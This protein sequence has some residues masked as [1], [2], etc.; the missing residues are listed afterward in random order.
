[1]VDVN[2]NP[3]SPAIGN[4]GRSFSNNPNTVATHAGWYIDEFHKLNLITAL[5]HFPGH[6]TVEADSHVDAPVDPRD[7]ETILHR[8]VAPFA[9]AI[10]AGLPAIMPAH[11][12][13]PEVDD[14]PA[15]FSSVWLQSVLRGQL[16]FQGAI[17]SDD[18]TMAGAAGA[19]NATE[20]AKS[21]LA[22]GC[23]M[24]LACN[25]RHGVRE[26]LDGLGEYH[27]PVSAIRLARLH[28]HGKHDWQ[29]L[30]SSAEYR[31][32][33]AAL[34]ALEWEPELDL[35]DDGPA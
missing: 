6:G 11:V 16:G 12:I 8:D 20:R 24:V 5:K 3:Y 2:V 29:A 4:Y 27:E 7:L 35:H 23:D 32:I 26:I 21:A 28:G 19:G 33:V 17:F 10:R 15:G 22:A 14:K 30:L 18:I 13:Y 25:D 34:S 31:E 1:V 9:E